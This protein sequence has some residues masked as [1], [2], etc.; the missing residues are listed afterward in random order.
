MAIFVFFAEETDIQ[1]EEADISFS[2]ST[3]NCRLQQ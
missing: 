3:Y 2:G 1:N